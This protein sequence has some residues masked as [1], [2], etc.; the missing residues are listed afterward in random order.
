MVE[1]IEVNGK[2][3]YSAL[4]ASTPSPAPIDFVGSAIAA[5]LL[6][7][8]ATTFEHHSF[9]AF[10]AIN[11]PFRVSLNWLSHMHS[12]NGV[13]MSPEP[14]AYSA[15]CTPVNAL[16]ESPSFLTLELH[17]TSPP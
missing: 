13:D 5:S 9:E 3:Y 17:A 12:L 4:P 11:G 16:V 15:T 10:M 6:S 1:S 14:V 8:L 7:G 2:T